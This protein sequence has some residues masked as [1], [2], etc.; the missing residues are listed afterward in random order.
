MS[1][2]IELFL[3]SIKAEPQNDLERFDPVQNLAAL[4]RAF[5]GSSVYLSLLDFSADWNAIL[6]KIE[7]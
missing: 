4:H 1:S 5:P 2:N 6:P 3:R 7:L